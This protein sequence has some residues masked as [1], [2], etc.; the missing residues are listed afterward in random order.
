ME[1]LQTVYLSVKEAAKYLQISQT[2][3][4]KRRLPIPHIR[5]GRRI[6]Y[7]KS[8]IETFLDSCRISPEE[9]SK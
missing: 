4:Y 5:L 7:R 6:I 1:E 3:L 9:A 8:D 2:S